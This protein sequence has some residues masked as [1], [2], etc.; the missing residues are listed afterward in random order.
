LKSSKTKL[1]NKKIK[2]IF[3]QYEEIPNDWNFKKI[4]DIGKVVG[5]GTPDTSKEEYWG[6]GTIPWYSIEEF[7]DTE[8]FVEKSEKNITEQSIQD[9]STTLLPIGSVIFSSYGTV[10]SCAVNLSPVATSQN[11]HNIICNKTHNNLFLLYAL[12]FHKRRIKRLSQVTTFEKII[13]EHFE[14]LE[15]PFPDDEKEEEEIGSIIHNVDSL[16]VIQNAI[17]KQFQKLKKGLIQKLVSEGIG[18]KKFRTVNLGKKFLSVK[19][20][21]TWKIFEFEKILNA[22][23]NKIELND[24]KT[25]T[26]ITVKR[27]H[28]GVVL[29]DKPLGK[30]ILVKNQF[31]VRAGDFVISK[32]QIIWNACGIIPQEFHGAVVSN[33][34]S[35]FS[36][37]ELLDIRYLD[38]FAQTRLFQQTIAVTTQGVDVEKYIFL[39]NEWLKL[40][41]PIPEIDEQRKIISIIEKIQSKINITQEYKNNLDKLKKGLMQQLLTGKKRVNI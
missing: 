27:R 5:G 25:Y 17:L 4:S 18:H 20:P 8:I 33:E 36:G 24:S 2:T 29:R 41:M 34:Y 39:D 26:R 15:F 30:D 11:F 28:E 16:I 40:K 21:E 23:K 12:K 19:I 3:N 35:N 31:K 32:R 13:K 14:S 37:T 1:K 7:D 22:E 10:G 9:S 6:N 38:L